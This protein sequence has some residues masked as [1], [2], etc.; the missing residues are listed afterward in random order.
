MI[1]RGEGTIINVAAMIAFSGPAGPEQ[2]PRRAVYTGTLAHS[3]AWT[4]QLHA[5]LATDGIK[6]QVVCP[7]ALTTRRRTE[8][9][10]T[11]RL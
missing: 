2:M 8:Q 10:R 6:V 5:E 3:V 4:Q 1:E 9:A 11:G 7:G